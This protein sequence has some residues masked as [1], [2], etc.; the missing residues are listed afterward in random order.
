MYEYP[1]VRSTAAIGST[2]SN[3]WRAQGSGVRDTWGSATRDS[4]SV[5]SEAPVVNNGE[6]DVLSG[7]EYTYM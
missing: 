3:I 2:S 4:F 6:S 1:I 5:D 7:A